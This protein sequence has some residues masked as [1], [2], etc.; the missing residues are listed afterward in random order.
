VTREIANRHW[1]EAF[2]D[3]VDDLGGEFRLFGSVATF[4][5]NLPLP[6]AN[7]ALV[8]EPTTSDD[9]ASA[10]SWVKSAGVPF[11]V[12]VDEPLAPQVERTLAANG[13]ERDPVPMPAMVLSPIP[14]APSAAPGVAVQRVDGAQYETFLDILINTG[15]PEKFALRIFPKHLVGKQNAAYL[16]ATLEGEPVG[17]SVAVQTGASGGI[18][19]VATL[20]KA[21]RRGVGS[22][23]TWAAIDAI[24]GWGC[25]A[26][27][28][29]SSEM[30]YSVYRAMGFEE[31]TRYVRFAPPASPTDLNRS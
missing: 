3:M 31:V 12:R 30:G 24:R 17:I 10:V 2:R 7:G 1:F 11:Q 26:A 16:V 8:L 25:T 5:G 18:Y 13:L 15:I 19:S 28:L 4:I 29:Q 6:F 20:D 22:A 27:V 9:L 14:V 23:V 21:R